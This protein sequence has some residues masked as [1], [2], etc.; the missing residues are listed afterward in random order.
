MIVI[1]WPA[2]VSVVLRCDPLFG[3]TLNVTLPLPVPEAPPVIDSQPSADVA[4]HAQLAP[5]AVTVAPPF[6]PSAGNVVALGAIENVQ[7]AGAVCVT[8]KVC[9]PAVIVPV[10][11]GPVLAATLNATAAL[12]V[13]LAA[14][15]I[16]IHETVAV[17]DQAHVA[18]VVMLNVPF[19]PG[20]AKDWLVGANA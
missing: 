8:V 17:A 14:D 12:P 19:P 5:L 2:T 18:P 3:A 7:G 6:P 20:S 10:R 13:P 1:A 11:S 15:V 4:V 9:P 16:A